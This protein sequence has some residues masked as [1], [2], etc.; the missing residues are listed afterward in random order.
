MK[1]NRISNSYISNLLQYIVVL[2]QKEIKLKF[3]LS[4]SNLRGK[5]KGNNQNIK[6][7][8]IYERG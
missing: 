7:K 6:G 4:W 1:I 3:I 2:Q 8:Y 5:K